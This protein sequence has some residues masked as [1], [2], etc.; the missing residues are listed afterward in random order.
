M[1]SVLL[2]SAHDTSRLWNF[3]SNDKQFTALW[4]AIIWGRDLAR[5]SETQQ[6]LQL[7]QYQQNIRVVLPFKSYIF[8][9]FDELIPTAMCNVVGTHDNEHVLSITP[10][11]NIT[12]LSICKG[13]SPTV[14]RGVE[15]W[16]CRSGN[17]MLVGS[18][19][20]D[21]SSTKNVLS[22]RDRSKPTAN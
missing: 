8:I 19:D 5:S 21:V 17:T 20:T 13:V 11:S 2:T 4:L 9:L 14:F 10:G 1:N 22:F 18:H 12:L 15:I 6:I 16:R 3:G 7:Y